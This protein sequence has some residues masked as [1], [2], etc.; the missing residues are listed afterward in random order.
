VLPDNA[1]YAYV[2]YVAAITIYAVY[3]L[4]I[5]WRGRTLAK[6]IRATARTTAPPDRDPAAG[7]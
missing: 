4:S 7:T 5:W 3:V 2:A 1:G 6:R